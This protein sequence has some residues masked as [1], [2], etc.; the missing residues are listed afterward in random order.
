[1]SRYRLGAYLAGA[2]V[3]RTA[4]DMSGPAL[5]LLGLAVTGSAGTAALLY[6]ALTIAGGCG[7]PLF[8]V[9][10]DRSAAPGRLLAWALAGY[11]GGLG[12]VAVFLGRL[13]LLAVA[14][15]AAAAGFLAPSL[16]G[17]WTS[18][19]PDIVPAPGLARGYSLDV[20]T[21]AAAA[22]IGPALAGL[23]AAAVG[24]G[25]AMAVVVALLM[26]AT[27]AAWRLP[28]PAPAGP[29]GH[30]AGRASVLA[31][32]RAGFGAILGVRPLLRITAC[33]V[34]A[35]L[36]V[37]MLVVACPLLGQRHLGGADRGALLL[38]LLAAASLIANAAQS[39]WPPRL[40]PDTM[41][42]LA[43]ALA[44]AAYLGLAAASSAGWVIVAIAVAGVADGPQ[45]SA[46]FAVRHREAPV[47]L[48]AQVFTT[49]ASLKLAAGALGAALAGHLA[50]S[51][52]L[53]LVVAAATQAAALLGF[54]VLGRRRRR[55]ATSAP[56]LAASRGSASSL[57]DI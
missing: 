12:V 48:R 14:G 15:L 47:R 49:A 34:I 30:P 29:A 6:A 52:A 55:K 32:L 5:L 40:A 18:R 31:D 28:R 11:A 7:G 4:D 35:Y 16:T 54:L 57:A 22:L 37:G 46:V 39:R 1:M 43:T 10:L 27:P 50:S 42:T 36:G 56:E 33:S 3:A 2:T 17:G 38:S 8:G 24:A 9:L 44:G 41:F 51:P 53:V 21:Y 23:V 20:S 45:L 19:L 25:W 13:P 26:V